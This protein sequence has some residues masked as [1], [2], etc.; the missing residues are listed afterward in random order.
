MRFHNHDGFGHTIS[1]KM[2]NA[3]VH[4]TAD[5]TRFATRAE[6]IMHRSQ[7]GPDKFR[8]GHPLAAFGA[9]LLRRESQGTQ[10]DT[11]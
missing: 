4:V 3:R 10:E 1:R 8:T 2:R 7:N 11:Y 6:Y 5:G 9:E